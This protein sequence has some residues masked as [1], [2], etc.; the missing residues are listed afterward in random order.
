MLDLMSELT[1]ISNGGCWA[2]ALSRASPAPVTFDGHQPV[3]FDA[4][5]LIW[6][7]GGR[8]SDGEWIDHFQGVVR[9]VSFHLNLLS[10]D[11]MLNIEIWETT[12]LW[13]AVLLHSVNRGSEQLVLGESYQLGVQMGDSAPPTLFS[14]NIYTTFRYSTYRAST[15]SQINAVTN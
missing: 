10:N 8:R 11:L 4:P 3:E 6:Q 15:K 7:C 9:L 12:F 2:L 14:S 5:I 1:T 13:T